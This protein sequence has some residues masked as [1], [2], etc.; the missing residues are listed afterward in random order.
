[1]EPI[2]SWEVISLRQDG[3]TQHLAGLLLSAPP[4]LVFC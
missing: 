3:L 2:L 1:M 4:D